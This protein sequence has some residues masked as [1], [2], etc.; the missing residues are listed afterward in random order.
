MER[1]ELDELHFITPI[2]NLPSICTH[3]ILS[4][5]GIRKLGLTHTSVAMTEVQD[6]R[7]GVTVPGTGK[8]LHDYANLYICARNPMLYKR[9]NEHRAL[10]VLRVSCDVLDIPGTVV[11]D[12]NAA[13]KEYSRFEPCPEGLS[14]VD[15]SR[16]FA[17]DWR[18]PVLPVFWRKRSQKCAEVLVP[19]SVPPKHLLGAYVSGDEAAEVFNSHKTGLAVTID[20]DFFFLRGF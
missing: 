6:I 2:A 11:T 1:A 20:P 10:C 12:G 5:N 9:K 16:T 8:P 17:R 3:G 19:S 7:K 13:A 18:D 15:R 14:C 4:H